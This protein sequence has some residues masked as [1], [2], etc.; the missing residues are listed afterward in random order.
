MKHFSIIAISL[1]V[2]LLGAG[3][4]KT[5]TIST[6]TTTTVNTSLDS[7]TTGVI[8]TSGN[9]NVSA[10]ITTGPAA[11]IT[12]TAPGVDQHTVTIKKGQT[13]RFLNHDSISHHLAVDPHPVHTDYPGLE[14]VIPPG[15]SFSF[16]FERTGSFGYHDHN[17]PRNSKFIGK[18]IVQ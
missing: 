3:C 16:T 7:N 17:D 5:A 11:T 10:T 9:A 4:K 6:N 8:D 1:A 15:D 12:Y 14:A 18:I 2:L 13:V